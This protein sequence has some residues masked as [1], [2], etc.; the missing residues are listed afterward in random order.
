MLESGKVS[1]FDSPINL[2]QTESSL[3]REMCH[4]TGELGV[5]LGMATSA[6]NERSKAQ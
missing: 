5:L 4:R 3:F 2:L 6:E 1:E